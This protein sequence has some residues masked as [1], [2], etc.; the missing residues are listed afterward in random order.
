MS[1]GGS[2]AV[3]VLF[4]ILF[5]GLVYWI[6]T[7]INKFFP[8]SKSW[9]EYKILRKKVN[10][11]QIKKLLQYY[12]AGMSDLDV[13]KLT[14]LSYKGSKNTIKETMYLYNEIQKSERRLKNE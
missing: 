11:D 13:K 7:A 1:I 14:L 2:L 9:F 3:A 4:V 10:E 8:H 12:D 6:K 5:A